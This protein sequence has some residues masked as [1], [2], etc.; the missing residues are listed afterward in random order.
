[1][2]ARAAR[3]TTKRRFFLVDLPLGAF[4]ESEEAAVHN[5]DP[6]RQE[7]APGREA[8]R[9]WTD[10]LG[11]A[12]SPRLGSRSWATSASLRDGDLPRRLQGPAHGREGAAG[13][14]STRSRYSGRCFS[15][16]LEACR[17]GLLGVSARR[18]RCRRSASVPAPT[19][20]ARCSCRTTCSGS[21]KGDAALRQALRDVAGEIRQGL[22]VVRGRGAQRTFPS[23]EHAYKISNEE[24]DLSPP[25]E[26]QVIAGDDS[27]SVDAPLD[28]LAD[29]VDG[30]DTQRRERSAEAATRHRAHREDD[31]A[32]EERVR[33][34]N[35]DRH[36]VVAELRE[37][38]TLGAVEIRIGPDD[39]ERRVAGP[40]ARGV[41]VARTSGVP[42]RA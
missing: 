4:Q 42:S 33:R 28:R 10:G 36:R 34:T 12:R 13:C 37:L 20:T 39:D 17:R 2:L 31:V 8:R 30:R 23:D 24:Y 32:V 11:R 7:A 9:R 26:V 14:T 38:S 19:A 1:M 3:R 41:P 29:R 18:C 6:I 5:A 21:T 16:V 22:A 27:I 40:A 25:D 35:P 15:L